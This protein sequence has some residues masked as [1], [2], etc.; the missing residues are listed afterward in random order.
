VLRG[1]LLTAP[2][3]SSR[4]PPARRPVPRP[5]CPRGPRAG[6][7]LRGP[8]SGCRRRPL[9]ARPPRGA[10]T[11]GL[12]A[13]PAGAMAKKSAENGIY[14]VSGDEKKGPLIVPGPDGAP[15]KGDGPA[16]PGAP[17]G[18]LAVPPRETWTRQMD[19]IMSCVGFAVGLGNVWRFPYLCYK[20]GGGELIP[21]PPQGQSPPPACRDPLEWRGE[22]QRVGRPF[23]ARGR[24]GTPLL[25]GRLVIQRDGLHPPH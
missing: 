17:G 6:P 13:R 8:P 25:A 19:F 1:L 15:A 23:R 18:R 21:T 2:P 20:N 11:P 4:T 24:R 10:A 7:R 16:G 14:S 22:V 5:G 12:A 3:P 9:P